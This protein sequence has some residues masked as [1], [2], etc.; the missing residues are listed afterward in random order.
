MLLAAGASR[1]FGAGDKLIAPFDGKPLGLHAVAALA[2]IPF[3][4]RIAVVSGTALDLA[5]HGFHCVPNH[6]Q[7]DGLA[8]SIGL[9][10]QAAR[11]AGVQAVLIALADMP[12]ITAAHVGHLLAE[13]DGPDA[14]VAS[15]NGEVAM[16]PVLFG[17]RHFDALSGR[18]GDA[19]PRALIRTGKSIIAAAGE[20]ADVDTPEDLARL[21]YA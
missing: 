10:V 8:H 13:A 16:P 9:G 21:T 4:I 17:R 7:A 14:V 18:T 12:R 2:S 15:S 20:L 6:R 5:A 1:R 3:A 11:E 19:G